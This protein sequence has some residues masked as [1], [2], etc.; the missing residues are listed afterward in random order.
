MFPVDEI[1]FSTQIRHNITIWIDFRHVLSIEARRFERETDHP[2][3]TNWLPGGK[4][5]KRRDFALDLF[6]LQNS[7]FIP[8]IS[9]PHRYIKFQ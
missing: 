1:R 6:I 8:I 3:T 7:V 5:H 2:G 4:R 9:F